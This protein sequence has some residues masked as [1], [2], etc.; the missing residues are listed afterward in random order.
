MK[1]KLASPKNQIS[2]RKGRFYKWLNGFVLF[3][4]I[5]SIIFVSI[6][7]C[8]APSVPTAELPHERLKSDYVLILLQC[9]LGVVAML[10]PSALYKHWNLM[11]P[12][13]M[14][15]AYTLFLYAAIFLGEVRNFYYA[16][17]HWD[18]VLH[19]F[20]GMMLGALGFSFI[21][22]LNNTEKIPLS[23]SPAFVAIFTFCFGVT[24]GVI[25]EFY[26][27]FADSV[28]LTNMQKYA[29]ESGEALAGH[30]ALTDTMKDLL[31]D[32][33][34]A[35]FISAIG[36]IS[37]KYKKGWIEKMLLKFKA[38]KSGKEHIHNQDQKKGVQEKCSEP[39]I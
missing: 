16:V 37:L 32:A 22:I 10:L 38:S 24:L 4:L 2:K 3:S 36:Y 1:T 29:L 23:L 33:I 18:T 35:A 6:E 15:T 20:S 14:L 28:L 34:G 12:P 7:I 27:F 5:A 13:Y 9:V 19:T 8:L 25:W 11:I 39:E 17:P 30:A 21:T 26:E 31:V